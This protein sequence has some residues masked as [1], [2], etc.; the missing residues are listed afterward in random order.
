[1]RRSPER[2]GGVSASAW[3]LLGALFFAVMGSHSPAAIVINESAHYQVGF[4]SLAVNVGDTVV[5]TNED[6]WPKVVRS[7]GGEWTSPTLGLGGVFAFTFT[8]RGFYA[9]DVFWG[10]AFGP[11]FGT[12]TVMGWTNQPPSVT[13]NTPIEGYVLVPYWY[14]PV[15][16]TVSDPSTLTQIQYFANSNLIGT[17]VSPSFDIQWMTTNAGPYTLFARAVDNQGKTTESPSVHVTVA[18][19]GGHFWGARILPRGQFLSFYYDINIAARH[20]FSFSDTP[21]YSN[22]TV[23]YNG[24]PAGVIVDE[25]AASTNSTRFY[26]MHVGG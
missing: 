16:A 14:F 17:G 8:N 26:F 3:G 24:P 7:Y 13:L 5:W 20:S 10:A 19:Q 21:F 18:A 11:P 9:Y 15:L 2:A 1:V 22:S 23:F 6:D 4:Q 12:V 25:S